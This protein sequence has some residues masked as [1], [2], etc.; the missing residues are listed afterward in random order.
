MQTKQYTWT[1][2]E[3]MEAHPAASLFPLM[4]EK[5]TALLYDGMK[6][7]GYNPAYPIVICEGMVLDGRNRRNIALRLYRE[8]ML[9]T[10]PPFVYYEGSNPIAFAVEANL[11]R[12]QLTTSEKGL[13]ALQLLPMVREE[14][15]KR[16]GGRPP[17]SPTGDK[18]PH[19]CAE[20]SGESR[21]IV[22]KMLG[23]SPGT[24]DRARRV[25][26]DPELLEKVKKGEMT[27]SAADEKLKARKRGEEAPVMD[28]KTHIP[29]DQQGPRKRLFTKNGLQV[30][31]NFINPGE[32]ERNQYLYLTV[33]IN[34][35]LTAQDLFN[36]YTTEEFAELHREM[37]LLLEG[38]SNALAQD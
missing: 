14:A 17:L 31:R 30:P 37:E 8:G 26:A 38:K 2:I 4:D 28:G 12:R 15:A 34:L 1:E 6:E 18:P 3:A 29:P 13:L 7:R 11:R 35:R 9:A 16:T 33:P 5:D 32:R 10:P 23:T 22:A 27:V 21:E 36:Y 25:S 24:V 20:V 19:N